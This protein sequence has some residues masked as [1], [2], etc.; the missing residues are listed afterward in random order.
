MSDDPLSA[1]SSGGHSDGKRALWGSLALNAKKKGEKREGTRWAKKG[2][3][4]LGNIKK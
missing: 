4:L 1:N 2:I 3:F